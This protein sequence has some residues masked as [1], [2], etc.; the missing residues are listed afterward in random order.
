[1]ALACFT[2]PLS[3][4][5]AGA[6]QVQVSQI[7]GTV[8]VLGSVWILAQP[9]QVIT[10]A[11]RTG[12]GRAVVNGTGT[13]RLTIGSSSV[14]RVYNGEPDMQSGR[15]YVKGDGALYA[16]GNH[17][18]VQG[19]L[20]L[21][22]SGSAQRVAVVSGSLRLSPSG[23]AFTLKAG[24]QYDFR[25]GKISSFTENDPWYLSQFIGQGDAVLQAS[26]GSVLT[27]PDAD[28]LRAAETGLVL[29]SGARLKTGPDAWA[30]IGF[31][32]GGYLRLQ[33]DS[34]LKVLGVEKTDRGR[35]VLLRLESGSAWNVV[36][37]GQGGYQLSTPTVTTAVRGTVF[38]VDASGLVKVF[39]G[40]VSLPSQG[41]A[42][43][44][45]GSQRESAG[46]LAQLK[47]DS[48]DTFNFSLD[49]AR[50]EH[51][52]LKYSEFPQVQDLHLDLKS[53]PG[54]RVSVVIGECQYAV[55][56]QNGAYALQQSLPEGR[57]T[58]TV[59]AE[60]PDQNLA[61]SQALTID[62]TPP[63]LSVSSV[64]TDGATLTVSGTVRD[65][66][67][68][69]PLLQAELNGQTYT[70]HASGP[71]SWTLPLNG[72]PGRPPTLRISASDDS[73]NRTYASL[74]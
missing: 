8:E 51:T 4:G 18:A 45:Q 27:G 19:E 67:S 25:T 6:R 23:Q 35:E 36:Q 70:L 53:T 43:V 50:A 29:A 62:H 37:K 13:S 1:M 63:T 66:F 31:S 71:F 74:P 26:R 47:T 5:V 65:N 14:M 64:A 60:R 10:T 38:R 54:A 40:A 11:L 68:G 20:R 32:G 46:K 56:G 49:A 52:V 48:L 28:H 24:Q 7:G 2:A 12:T 72:D 16:F 44:G 17:L 61:I 15:F 30:E 21:D 34:Q 22:A 9:S 55:S 39:D 33:A 41:D 59:R 69:L 73:G 57:Y 42:V 58:L 3:L